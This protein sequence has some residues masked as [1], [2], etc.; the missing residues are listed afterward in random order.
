MK[1]MIPLL[2]LLCTLTA[3]ASGAPEAADPPAETDP[4]AE[5]AP[6]EETALPD[7]MVGTSTFAQAAP[8]QLTYTVT[9]ETLENSA[10]AEDGTVLVNRS[11]HLPMMTVK[12]QDGTAVTAA[13][14]PAETA[15]LAAAETF[16]GQFQSWAASDNFDEVADWAE[17]AQASQAEAGEAA[18]AWT[19]YALELNCS[20]YQTK[21]LVSVRAEY[22]SYMGGAHPNTVLLAWNFDLGTGQFF[23]PELLAADGQAFS[24]A[25]TEELI[26]Q[27]QETA[28]SYDMTPEDFFWSNYEEILAGWSSYAVSFDETGMT[29]GFSPYE[30]AAYAAGAQIYHLDYDQIAGYLSSHGLAVLGLAAVEK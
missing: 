7:T 9:L 11:Y 27:S 8:E 2:L 10:Q 20:V 17:E 16:N 1:R 30:L 21:Q 4:S 25:V 15:A 29:V 3:C 26:R 28:A 24:Q 18:G 5:T 13:S 14:T 6:Q 19:P 22:Y 23:T 12:R